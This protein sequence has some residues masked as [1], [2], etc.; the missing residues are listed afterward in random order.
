MTRFC[1]ATTMYRCGSYAVSSLPWCASV[2][3][4]YTRVNLKTKSIRSALSH[5]RPAFESSKEPMPKTMPSRTTKLHY[6]L[7]AVTSCPT[8]TKTRSLPPALCRVG[9]AQPPLPS[10]PGAGYGAKSDE[11]SNLQFFFGSES[12]SGRE[13]ISR[14]GSSGKWRQR[15]VASW[16]GVVRVVASGRE[17]ERAGKEK[18]ER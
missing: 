10:V 16:E 1:S 12:G 6:R 18:E 2:R 9:A 14:S 5:R 7:L 13:C 11:V 15:T 8:T 3:L 17:R 4:S